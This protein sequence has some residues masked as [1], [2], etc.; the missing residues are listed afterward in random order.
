VVQLS[1]TIT[2]ER[3][4]QALRVAAEN[5]PGVRKVEEYLTWMDPIS[6]FYV[7]AP[8]AER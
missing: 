8:P 5:V 2:D 1:G 7:E 3:Q 4:R 6:G